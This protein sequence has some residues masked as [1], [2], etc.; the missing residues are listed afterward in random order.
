[1][2]EAYR[3]TF[4]VD[5]AEPISARIEKILAELETLSS[6]PAVEDLPEDIQ[7]ATDMQSVDTFNE[8]DTGAAEEPETVA[9][10]QIETILDLPEIQQSI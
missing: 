8:V 2:L 9:A 1:M 4:F 7:T 10:K 3:L 6:E 5:D